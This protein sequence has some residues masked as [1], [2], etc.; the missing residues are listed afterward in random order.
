M[1]KTGIHFGVTLQNYIHYLT[2]YWL[3]GE[4]KCAVL[5]FPVA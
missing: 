4:W 1:Q 5:G 3:F 2:N